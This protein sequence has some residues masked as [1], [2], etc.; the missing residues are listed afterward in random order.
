M[1]RLDISSLE[2][3]K[4]ILHICR[5]DIPIKRQGFGGG[6]HNVALVMTLLARA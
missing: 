5:M 6:K 1:R 3:K 4:L 2:Y